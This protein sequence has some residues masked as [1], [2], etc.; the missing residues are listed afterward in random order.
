MMVLSFPIGAYVF[1][2][3]DLGDTITHEYPLQYTDSFLASIWQHVPFEPSLGDAFIVIW[4]AALIL[5]GIGM[6]GPRDN[7][8]NAL[9][10]AL[11]GGRDSSSSCVASVLKWFAIIVFSS[12]VLDSIQQAFGIVIRPPEFDN[13]LVRFFLASLAPFI[14]EIGFRVILVGI[15]LYVMFYY[16]LSWRVLAKSLW[17]PHD[18]LDAVDMRRVIAL[19]ILVGVMFGLVH[20]LADQWSLGKIS[21]AAVSGVILGW[22]YYRHGLAAALL[23]HWAINYFVFSYVHFVAYVNDIPVKDASAHSLLGTLEL[24]FFVSGAVSLAFVIA[25]YLRSRNSARC[26]PIL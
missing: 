16:K 6:I 22:V 9:L 15:P 3:S 24:L 7:V 21:Q 2:N 18:N 17:R 26:Q 13:E 10:A 4:A 5:F 1:F 12:V 19:I 25:N 20:V 23:L 8:I 14:E 11:S